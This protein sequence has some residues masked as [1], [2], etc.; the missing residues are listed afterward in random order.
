ML[1]QM[2]Q[3]E[4]SQTRGDLSLDVMYIC[5]IFQ[6]RSLYDGMCEVYQTP[7]PFKAQW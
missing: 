5:L 4:Q 7:R 2:F 3:I 6:F 1:P